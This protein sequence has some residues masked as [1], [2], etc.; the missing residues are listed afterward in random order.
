MPASLTCA[1]CISSLLLY[2]RNIDP[3]TSIKPTTNAEVLAL[4]PMAVT[5]V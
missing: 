5:S 4:N 3:R 2:I 1:E